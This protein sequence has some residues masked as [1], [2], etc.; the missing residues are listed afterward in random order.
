MVIDIRQPQAYYFYVL[1][2]KGAN[3]KL[4]SISLLQSCRIFTDAVLTQPGI[5]PALIDQGKELYSDLID[6]IQK[7]LFEESKATN[8]EIN[9]E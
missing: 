3:M 6:E 5:D 7:I 1:F 9:D 8:K 4:N 2:K